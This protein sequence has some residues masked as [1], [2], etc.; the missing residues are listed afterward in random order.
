MTPISV[1]LVVVLSAIIICCLRSAITPAFSAGLMPLVLGIHSWFYPMGIFLALCLLVLFLKAYLHLPL[2]PYKHEGVEKKTDN[3][4]RNTWWPL[5][6]LGF[7]TVM[8]IAA[9]GTGLRFILFPPLTVIS[10][11][12]FRD[13]RQCI[14][15]KR[16]WLLI[17]SCGLTATAG[18][19]A[20]QM[21]PNMIP[22]ATLISMALG[23]AVITSLK[24]NLAPALAVGIIPMIL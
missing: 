3:Q 8:A 6:W 21:L 15:A 17:G 11:Q 2:S 7:I 5:L 22:L 14:F 9:Q 23:I 19:L 13:P 16:P 10:Y 1:L 24:V 20:A 12:A 4:S 18:V